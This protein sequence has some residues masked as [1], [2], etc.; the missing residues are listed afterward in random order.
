VKR[1]LVAVL[2]ACGSTP[3]PS[4]STPEQPA[5]PGTTKW[6]EG[7]NQA[8]GA[9]RVGISNM[10]VRDG[11][12]L[13]ATFSILEA[14]GREHHEFVKV[15]TVVMVCG[16]SIEVVRIDSPTPGAVFVRQ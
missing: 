6:T 12:G 5:P 9:C 15:G 7:T 1:T 8:V 4:P 3:A 11:L 16:V 14:D 2:V 13:S 10:F